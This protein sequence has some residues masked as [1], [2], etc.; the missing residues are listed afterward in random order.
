MQFHHRRAKLISM[1]YR[2]LIDE[3]WYA[4]EEVKLNLQCITLSQPVS[5]LHWQFTPDYGLV[6]GGTSP[7][8]PI[9]TTQR[10]WQYKQLSDLTPPNAAI[11]RVT[12]DR[13]E[14]I[15]SALASTGQGVS[16]IHIANTGA[17]RDAI[18]SGLPDDLKEMRCWV[19]DHTRSM[20]PI[21]SGTVSGGT[22]EVTIPAQSFL[23]LSR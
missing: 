18:I 7:S 8:D 9:K 20:Q 21:Y 3:P 2:T 14:I 19:T 23:T 11:L 1:Q 17:E 16:V 15:A 10:W 22:L 13:P 5:I 6:T 4:L 12:S